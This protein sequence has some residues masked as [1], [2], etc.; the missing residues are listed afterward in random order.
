MQTKRQ[1]QQLLASAGVAPNRR[2]G[3]NFLVDLNLARL[4]IDSAKIGS[5]DVVL[6]VGPGTGSLT[7]AMAPQSGA[8]VAVEMPGLQ[9]RHKKPPESLKR[10][11]KA[12]KK[13]FY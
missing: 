12:R 5:D 8:V 1:V 10:A 7:E 4:L 9:L 11:G 2:F 13:I 3:Q 6:E